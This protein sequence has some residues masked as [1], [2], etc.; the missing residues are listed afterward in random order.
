MSGITSG[1]RSGTVD[2]F[3]DQINSPDFG[4]LYSQFR[5]TYT[6]DGGDSGAP[7]FVNYGSNAVKLVGVHWGKDTATGK[8]YFS[9]IGGVIA[10]LDVTPMK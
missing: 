1:T 6:C 8:S 9:P 2:R 4:I 10:D 5:A 3:Y 7:V